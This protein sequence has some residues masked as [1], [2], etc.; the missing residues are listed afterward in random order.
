MRVPP[1][2]VARSSGVPVAEGAL[3]ASGAR[4]ALAGFFISGVLISFLGA[5]LPAWQHHLSSEYGIVGFYFV[6][7][8]VGLVASVGVAPRLLESKGVGWT[9]ALACAV[10][11][12]GFLYLAFVSPPSSPW[13]RVAGMAII[14]F[15]AGLLHTAVFH[16]VSPMYRHDPVATVNLAG[17][18]FGLGCLTVAL[19]ISGTFYMYSAPALQAWIAVIPAAFG[20]FYFKTPFSPLP[21]PHH[22]PLRAIFSEL[23]TPAAV[24][25]ALLLFFQLGNEWALAGW[26]SLFLT[27]RLGIS[28]ATSLSMLALYWLALLVGRVSAQWILPKVRHSRLLMVSAAASILGCVILLLTD[29]RFGAVTGILLLGGAFA[30]IYPLVIEKIGH[31]FPYFHPGFYNGIFSCA[32]AGGLLSPCLVGYLASEWGVLTVIGLPLVGTVVVFVLLL[33]IGLE[34]RLNSFKPAA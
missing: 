18:L 2:E 5:I 33:L 28:P 16:A 22:P 25:L 11:G 32:L 9:L 14:G 10:A 19:L 4:R 26:L 24:L 13:W 6:G 34:A 12:I 31:R 15:S 21:V 1:P 30:P 8:I 29:N 3:G 27:Q 7:L 17:I 20:W 23:R